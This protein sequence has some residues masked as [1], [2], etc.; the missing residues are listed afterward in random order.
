M[1]AV[2]TA[3]PMVAPMLPSCRR[4]RT[5]R[6]I[7]YRFRE[8]ADL[9]D[10]SLSP[11]DGDRLSL[12]SHVPLVT[13]GDK[14]EGLCLFTGL[15][16]PGLLVVCDAPRDARLLGADAVPANLFELPR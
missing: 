5:G 4:R 6:Q 12:A 11:L 3:G 15:D 2:L 13:G 14:A 1:M 16:A 7:L 8:T 9:D 10:D